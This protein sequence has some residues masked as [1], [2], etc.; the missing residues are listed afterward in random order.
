MVGAME[1]NL[2]QEHNQVLN[3][4]TTLP[5]PSPGPPHQAL[6]A[7]STPSGEVQLPTPWLRALAFSP[8]CYQQLRAGPCFE[9]EDR[10]EL[11][12]QLAPNT[13]HGARELCWTQL[14][15]VLPAAPGS[16]CQ[17]TSP[18][19]RRSPRLRRARS[20]ARIPQVAKEHHTR[21]PSLARL[22]AALTTHVRCLPSTHA[23]HH[24]GARLG[25]GKK[26]AGPAPRPLPTSR[27][28]CPAAQAETR[29]GSGARGGGGDARRGERARC[30][31]GITSPPRH[32]ATPPPGLTPSTGKPGPPAPGPAGDSGDWAARPRPHPPGTRS[33]AWAFRAPRH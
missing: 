7:F 27:Q 5:G 6:T 8:P 30:D 20:L 16:R 3:A 2:Q 31:P 24:R 12:E 22:E 19:S 1:K 14:H 13:S 9:A 18:F 23:R 21:T 4:P 25:S 28:P 17:S 29:Q 32:P 10:R 11:T 26:V 15:L 33:A